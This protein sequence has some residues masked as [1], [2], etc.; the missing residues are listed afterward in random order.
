MN[1]QQGLFGIS[2]SEFFTE[3]EPAAADMS[4]FFLEL[5]LFLKCLD[6]DKD[7]CRLYPSSR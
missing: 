2:M 7:V 5:P 4:E 1:R 3:K 6:G